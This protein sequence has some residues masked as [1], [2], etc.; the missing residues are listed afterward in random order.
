MGAGRDLSK[1]SALRVPSFRHG[2]RAG[3]VWIQMTRF[4]KFLGVV[5]AAAAT[6]GAQSGSITL[7]GPGSLT[8]KQGQSVSATFQLTHK[9]KPEVATFSISGVPA[10]VSA[11]FL[12]ASCKGDCQ[13]SLTIKAAST[14]A[15]GNYNAIIRAQSGSNLA[16]MPMMITVAPS[17]P[18][19]SPAG[20]ATALGIT[21]AEVAVW[22]DRAVNGPYK[23]DG[24]VSTNS[25]GDWD[26]A[27][28]RAATFAASPLSD[29]WQGNTSAE[30]WH[31]NDLFCNYTE[32]TGVEAACVPSFDQGLNILA[33][34][35]V[36][37]VMPGTYSYADEVRTAL[38][39]E[40]AYAGTDWTNTAK[41]PD[42]QLGDANSYLIAYYLSRIIT[43][44]SYVRENAVFSVGER[45]AIDE[46]FSDAAYYW[47]KN[48]NYL[49][50]G[51]NGVHPNRNTEFDTTVDVGI[52]YTTDL[53]EGVAVSG[54]VVTYFD[55]DSDVPGYY[56]SGPS[57]LYNNRSSSQIT[58]AAQGA[59]LNGGFAN[60]TQTK[61]WAYMWF[62]EWLTYSMHANGVF[63]DWQRGLEDGVYNQ[64]WVYSGIVLGNM[65]IIA[66]LFA[67]KNGDYSLYDFSTSAGWTFGANNPVGFTADTAGGPKSLLLGMQTHYT[68]TD[69]TPDWRIGTDV[70]VCSDA[71]KKIAADGSNASVHENHY[72]MNNLY[73]RDATYKTM[74]L[75]TAAGAPAYPADPTTNSNPW[76][77]VSAMH[78]GAL[79]QFG[80]M[81]DDPA[82]PHL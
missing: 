56:S 36:T 68:I 60:D 65:G 41:W 77:G 69:G 66:D 10:E 46:W 24:D 18:I 9:G 12:P 64:G 11:A 15:T 26:S 80:D 3:E 58:F 6:M 73:Y 44:Y 59:F 22:A 31:P 20:I 38:L 1:V 78:A 30:P 21:N 75:R 23:S 62:K 14:A 27:V 47:A 61:R 81:E 70:S 72:V 4:L 43:A 45:A 2:L 13:T 42:E 57:S 49:L 74:Y 32:G 5:A 55:C 53:A 28:S 34:A 67:R 50:T 19:P 40:I 63:H 7:S 51:G 17:L 39:A 82:N 52:K 54:G 25:P 37:L 8:V 76:G 79:F 16:T 48:V 33:A 71:S 35:F 29:N